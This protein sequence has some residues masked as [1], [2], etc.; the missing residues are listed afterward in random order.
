MFHLPVYI[1]NRNIFLWYPDAESTVA[2]LPFKQSLLREALFDPSG[3]IAFEQLRRF[4]DGNCR[5]NYREDMNVINCANDS[6]R[7]HSVISCNASDVGIEFFW[8][9]V[10]MVRTRSLVEKTKWIR[11]LEYVWDILYPL[12]LC[13][14]YGTL[15]FFCSHPTNKLVGYYI[16]SLR[17]KEQ[18]TKSDISE[19]VKSQRIVF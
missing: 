17:D 10:D 4:G 18:R 11:Q 2:F 19:Y 8:I 7:S 16:I 14:A 1:S 15:Y 9:S 13:R 3:W 12:F 5:R 6:E